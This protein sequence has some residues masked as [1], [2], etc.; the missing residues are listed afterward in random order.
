MS[1]P[2]EDVWAL[3]ILAFEL[4][5]GH[6][7]WPDLRGA[8]QA[9]DGGSALFA[10]TMGVLATARMTGVGR[11]RVDGREEQL[12]YLRFFARHSPAADRVDDMPDDLR[13]FLYACLAPAP[14][15]RPTAEE[16]LNH[17]LFAGVVSLR[18]LARPLL[19][20]ADLGA[21]GQDKL[22][23]SM[24]S[25]SP[26]SASRHLGAGDRDEI[27]VPPSSP[28]YSMLHGRPLAD[29]FHLWTLAGG[30]VEADMT[31]RGIITTRPPI[32][33]L[34]RLV[35]HGQPSSEAGKDDSYRYSAR[36]YTLDL[37]S[38]ERRLSEGGLDPFP[39][40]L[41][42]PLPDTDDVG[43]AD[44][45]PDAVSAA[46]AAASAETAASLPLL[47]RE[48]DIDYQFSRMVLMGRLLRGS[49][50]TRDQIRDEASK[51]VPPQY[52]GRTWA[53]LLDVDDRTVRELYAGIDTG[54]PHPTDHQLAVDIPRC[55]QYDPLMSSPAGHEK[56]RRVIKAW[57]LHN[58]DLVY[59]QGLDSVTAPFLR[60]HFN[61]EALA[62]G[63]L[64]NFV[65]KFLTGFFLKDNSQVMQEHLAVFTHLL[66]T[67][68][69]S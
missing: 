12:K 46:A 5:L 48:R 36:H 54:V 68:T 17:D 38:L 67:T 21:P 39:S 22:L 53:C 18:W 8:D 28:S 16:L 58:P 30:D 45:Y 43:A 32:L 40:I 37:A 15:D 63:C 19:R 23:E 50:F 1:N 20:S 3:G 52:R 64:H 33:T 47:I 60:L 35:I 55:H 62:F 26:G 59:W 7:L 10:R 69:Q 51:D 2:K 49:P 44:A 11:R 29:V 27:A 13:A 41:R 66:A 24:F 25:A 14:A 9:A 4:F 34:P 6:R 56:L 31:R 65:Q 61:D 42:S 57:I